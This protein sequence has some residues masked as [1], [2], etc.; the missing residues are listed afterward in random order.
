MKNCIE[1]KIHILERH[2]LFVHASYQYLSMNIKT[3]FSFN[4]WLEKAALYFT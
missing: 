4:V 1:C 2:V 3:E